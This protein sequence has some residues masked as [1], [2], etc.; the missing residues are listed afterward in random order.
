MEKIRNIFFTLLCTWPNGPV[1]AKILPRFQFEGKT[2][3]CQ[4]RYVNKVKLA[5]FM[6]GIPVE[7]P[8]GIF[9]RIS[10]P[11]ASQNK[12]LTVKVEIF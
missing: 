1:R 5:A 7:I 6:T 10:P 8:T 12:I 3:V 11:S 2:D 9:L 4:V